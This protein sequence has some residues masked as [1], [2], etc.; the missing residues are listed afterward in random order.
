MEHC[1]FSSVRALATP[2]GVKSVFWQMSR[3]FHPKDRDLTFLVDVSD[4]SL[5]DWTCL[6]PTPLTDVCVFTDSVTRRF[7]MV[8][9][10]W[11]RVRAVLSDPSGTRPSEELPSVPTQLTGALSDKGWLIASNMVRSFYKTLKKGGGQQ[12][13]FLKRRVWGNKCP[14]CVDFDVESVV[15]VH[16]PIC[17]GTGIVGGYYQGI[18]FWIMP[19]PLSPRAR[20]ESVDG[21]AEE[22]GLSGECA[23]Y[24]WID[25]YDIWVDARTDERFVVKSVASVKEIE[26]KPVIF[27][28]SLVKMAFTDIAMDIPVASTS[29]TFETVDD[30]SKTQKPLVDDYPNK[31]SESVASSSNVDNGWRTG[32]KSEDW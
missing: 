16:C 8:S 1:V 13:F 4:S 28:L 5:G 27:R 3:D 7:G 17:Y 6:T 21:M 26:R 22:C 23:A 12:G 18:P 29:E 25:A 11:Y 10:I 2:D 24:P 9:D 32:L 30:I 20:A 31:P 14:N 15:N 19:T